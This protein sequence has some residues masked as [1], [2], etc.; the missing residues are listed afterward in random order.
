MEELALLEQVGP[1]LM[2]ANLAGQAERR[3]SKRP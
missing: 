2:F 1:G 3:R